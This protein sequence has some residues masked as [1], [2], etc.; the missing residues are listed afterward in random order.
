MIKTNP[1]LLTDAYKISHPEQYPDKTEFIYSNVT[2]RKS[3]VKGVNSIV[4]L[5]VKYF[6][7]HYLIEYFN[8]NFF[9]RDKDEVIEELDE[10]FASYFGK[11]AVDT[12]KYADLHDLGYLPL[13]I[14]SLREGSECPIGVPFM[15][16]ENTKPEFYWLTNFIETLSQC[17]MWN[18]ITAATLAKRYRK[19]LDDFANMTSSQP[20][21]VDFQAHNFSM[22]G[23]SSPESANTTDLG[24]LLFFSGSDTLS[25]NTLV[26]SL[27]GVEDGD[28]VSA[29]VPATEHAVMCAGGKE[30]ELETFRRLVCDLYPSGIVSIV[31]DTWDLWNVLSNIM[32]S[33]KE[34]IESRDGRVVIRPDSGDPERIICGYATR[35]I[36]VDSKNFLA[37]T[38]NQDFYM[39]YFN[40]N[41]A[42]R[43]S[44]GKI[45]GADLREMSE[46]EVKGCIRLLDEH[47][48]STLNGKGFKEINPKVGLIY[49]DA[50]TYERAESICSTLMEMG[51]ASTNVVFGVGSFTYQ[52]NTRDTFSIACKA[53][54]AQVDGVGRDIFKDPVTD[55]GTKKSACGLLQ[56]VEGESGMLEVKQKVQRVD[57][58][59]SLLGIVFE[60]GES[61]MSDSWHIIQLRASC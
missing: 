43:C 27:Y 16:I 1:I 46:G 35:D 4:V 11:D 60:D 28:F 36:S 61:F 7:E 39:L 15:T 48:G 59:N 2:A 52:M 23:M 50:I 10:F 41:E 58:E 55:D 20:E 24:H 53:T 6:I 33:L 9:S 12:S 34:E 31:S 25:G 3:R 37:K 38:R 26:R 54:W 57:E 49:G 42:V 5:G 22:R 32:P 45:F 51:Y 47:F 19:M 17:V 8:E 21:F 13:R 56:V 44:D 18:P 40:G 29:S 30:D 14:K